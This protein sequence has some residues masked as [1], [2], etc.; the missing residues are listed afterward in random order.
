[1]PRP[2][3][4]GGA[5]TAGQSPSAQL[6][7][8]TQT[9][10]DALF[11]ERGLEAGLLTPNQVTEARALQAQ[12]A[13][14]GLNKALSGIF[15][16]RGVLTAEQVGV[17]MNAVQQAAMVS[18][19][20]TVDSGPSDPGEDD[21]A[22]G[23]TEIIDYA[24]APAAGTRADSAP[25]IPGFAIERT[26]GSGGMGTV[27]LARR[28]GERVALKVLAPAMAKDEKYRKLFVREA[29][30]ARGLTHPNVV[31]ILEAGKFGFWNYVVMEFVDGE[32]LEQKLKSRDQIKLKWCYEVFDQIAAGLSYIHQHGIIHRDIKPA[33]RPMRWPSPSVTAASR[34]RTPVGSTRSMRGRS[35]GAG[36]AGR[37]TGR[38]VPTRGPR[39][40]TGRPSPSS[41]RPSS[42]P[43]QVTLSGA[44]RVV[45]RASGA[46]PSALPSGNRVTAC[47][48]KPTTSHASGRSPSRSITHSSPSRAPGS[49]AVSARPTAE[50]RR[51]SPCTVRTAVS[52]SRSCA[53]SSRIAA[54]A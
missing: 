18:E 41:T 10:L 25:A 4:H 35:I 31:P 44:P 28:G 52:R 9:D 38:S 7:A 20:D 48:A 3:T 49:S 16:D 8:L 30:V 6:A 50:R 19:V 22:H 24:K 23:V 12:V 26:L 11:V 47:S 42:E 54:R 14:L 40:S 15:T 43:P 27:Y 45:T 17:V 13:A 37:I 2:A 5:R 21:D 39:P 33:N 29:K 53:V 46:R 34:A 1:V 32:T 51:P 36:V